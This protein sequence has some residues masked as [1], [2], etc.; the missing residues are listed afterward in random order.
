V[1][2]AAPASVE[3]KPAIAR[4]RVRIRDTAVGPRLAIGLWLVFAFCV[5]NV[6][7]DRAIVVAGRQYVAAAAT[8]AS[9]HPPVYLG[10]DE[11]MR[12][13]ETRAVRTATAAAGGLLA[14]GL[15]GVAIA[16]RGGRATSA[17]SPR[18]S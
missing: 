12:A 4:L 9:R 2:E 15:A 6:V 18:R 1:T 3:R 8:S 7:F 13:A 5:W 10:I 17:G 11:W 14:L 16:A